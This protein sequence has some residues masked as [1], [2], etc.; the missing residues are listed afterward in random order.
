MRIMDN[1]ASLSP[2][3]GMSNA[4]VSLLNETQLFRPGARSGFINRLPPGTVQRFPRSF[5]LQKKTAS[6]SPP[7]LHGP[8]SLPRL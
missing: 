8:I 5:V 2:Q 4:V 6:A 1:G 7:N 3:P